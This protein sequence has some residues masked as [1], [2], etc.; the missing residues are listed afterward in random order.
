MNSRPQM[1]ATR[2]SDVPRSGWSITRIHGGTRM[3][4]APMIVQGDLILDWRPARK[5]AK[6]TTMM[7]LA[8]SLNWNWNPNTTTHRAA[9]PASPVPVPSGAS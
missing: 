6:T 2:T 5:A 4:R 8:S 3:T 1:V 7:I 9:V